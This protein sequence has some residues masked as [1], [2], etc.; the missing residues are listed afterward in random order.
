MKSLLKTILVTFLATTAFWIL[1]ILGFLWV[2]SDNSGVAFVEDARQSGFIAMLRATN[3]ETHPVTFSI[4]ELHTTLSATE[5][6][7][8][9][10][11]RHLPPSGELWVGIKKAKSE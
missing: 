3:T 4:E 7:V 5:S 1:A 2:S 10:L 6:A 11:E 8:I 9:L